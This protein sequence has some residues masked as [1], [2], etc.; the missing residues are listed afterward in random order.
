VLRLR[1]A[2][3]LLQA[4]YSAAVKYGG[5]KEFDVVLSVYKKPPSPQHEL[6]ALGS[7]ASTRD[8]ALLQRAFD[9]IL[10]GEVR[11]QNVAAFI[12]VK[13]SVPSSVM[14]SFPL[15]YKHG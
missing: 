2:V 11:E 1:S 14:V 13:P 8:D 5:Q 10:N 15:T 4:I 9:L 12:R 6:S 3:D 7:L